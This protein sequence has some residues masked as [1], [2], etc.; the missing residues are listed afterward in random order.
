MDCHYAIIL[1]RAMFLYLSL[2]REGWEELNCFDLNFY[3]KKTEKMVHYN[4]VDFIFY[5]S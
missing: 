1:L 4:I 2:P 3:T 5:T